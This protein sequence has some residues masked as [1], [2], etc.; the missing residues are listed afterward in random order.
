MYL[1]GLPSL[2]FKFFLPNLL[3]QARIIDQRKLVGAS[4]LIPC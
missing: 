2:R 4:V 1:P 3:A